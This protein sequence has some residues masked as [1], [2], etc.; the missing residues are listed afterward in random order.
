[1]EGRRG[2]ADVR[3]HGGAEAHGR[4][5]LV[6]TVRPALALGVGARKRIR[7]LAHVAGTMP[8]P[9]SRQRQ[10]SGLSDIGGRWRGNQISTAVGTMHPVEVD[11]ENSQLL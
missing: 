9:C 11:N 2:G 10:A 3:R 6:D 4:A 5:E 7:Q 8:L 1:M